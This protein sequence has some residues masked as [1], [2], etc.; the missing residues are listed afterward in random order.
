MSICLIGFLLVV[1]ALGAPNMY[2][3]LVGFT[4]IVCVVDGVFKKLVITQLVLLKKFGNMVD[5]IEI[6]WYHWDT[7]VITV[8][9]FSE[10]TKVYSGSDC[11]WL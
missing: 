10:I 6:F 4:R 8:L 7:K 11:K 2:Q 3:N 5:K 1:D 9:A